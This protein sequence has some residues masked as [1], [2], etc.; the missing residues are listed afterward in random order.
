MKNKKK[1]LK[2]VFILYAVFLTILSIYSY[3]LVDLNLTLINH[4]F[5]TI[6]RNKII[7]LGYYK[8]ELSS[9]IYTFSL[10]ILFA[11]HF[12]FLKTK[13]K[14]TTLSAIIFVTTIFSYPFLSHDFFNYLFDSK[15]L[16]FYKKN[17]YLYSALDFPEDPWLRFMHWTHRKYP[18]GPFFIFLTSIPFFFAFSKFFLTY[19]LTK[20]FFSLLFILSVILISKKNNY[21]GLFILT[22]PLIIIEGFINSHNDIIALSLALIGIYFMYQNKN[23]KAYLFFIFSALIKY[24][25]LPLFL[26]FKKNN[27][28]I[29]LSFLGIV[30]TIFFVSFKREIQPWYFL[31]LFIFV[32]FFPKLFKKLNLLF[33]F[34]LMSYYPYIRFSQ[35]NLV[36]SI[37]LKHKI[38]FIGFIIFLLFSWKELKNLFSL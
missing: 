7:I 14:I 12:Y 22:N 34:L 28:L 16:V 33:F 8:R 1:F 23:L 11:F 30:A 20:A 13:P 2:T 27:T 25:T 4:P 35:W 21:A 19:F 37:E 5:W 18:Y 36:S 9:I 29:K 17:P 32:P 24:I 3:S 10:I 15:I 6:F 26:L 38:I 31:N